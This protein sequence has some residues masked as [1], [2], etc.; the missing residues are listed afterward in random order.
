MGPI[1]EYKYSF[2]NLTD[3]NL[4]DATVAS[5]SKSFWLF[6]LEADPNDPNFVFWTLTDR[7][8]DTF[9]DPDGFPTNTFVSLIG[10]EPISDITGVTAET[11]A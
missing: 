4:T 3:P 10:R 6:D 1:F 2:T 7:F 8:T 11:R 9:V 5:A